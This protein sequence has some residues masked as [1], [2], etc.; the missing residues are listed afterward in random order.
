MQTNGEGRTEGCPY[1]VRIAWRVCLCDLCLTLTGALV[2]QVV[3]LHPSTIC[4]LGGL[5]LESRSG[6]LGAISCGKT[7]QCVSVHIAQLTD[8]SIVQCTPTG[9]ALLVE[10]QLATSGDWL[11]VGHFLAEE[12]VEVLRMLVARIAEMVVRNVLQRPRS[13]AALAMFV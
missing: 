6:G 1:L 8:C 5:E 13:T 7:V 9:K 12:K 3:H 10:A 2:F 4:C 11:H